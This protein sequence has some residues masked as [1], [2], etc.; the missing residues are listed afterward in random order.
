MLLLHYLSL[1]SNTELCCFQWGLYTVQNTSMS[2][3]QKITGN[4]AVLFRLIYLHMS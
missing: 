3:L 4:F 1:S 2:G